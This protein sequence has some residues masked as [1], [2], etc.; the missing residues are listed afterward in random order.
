VGA[1][2]TIQSTTFTVQA[3]QALDEK[4]IFSFSTG[5]PKGAYLMA[6]H[7]QSTSWIDPKG[8][9]AGSEFAADSVVVPEP[10]QP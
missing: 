5:G 6:I 1:N 8:N 2:P 3:D 10:T 4:D 9:V 7:A